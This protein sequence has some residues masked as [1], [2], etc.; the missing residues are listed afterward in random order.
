[1]RLAITYHHEPEMPGA[2]AL[3]TIIHVANAIVHG[4]DLACEEGD[5]VPAVSPAAWTAL[6]LNE[7]AYLHVFRET[8]LQ[9]EEIS[10]V[11]M[12]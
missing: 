11:L 5:L 3:A 6:G 8:E 12:G 10:T 4:L 2:G 9:F 1:M 7:E